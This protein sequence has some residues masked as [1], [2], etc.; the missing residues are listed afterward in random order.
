M[1]KVH[2]ED[3]IIAYQFDAGDQSLGS[4]AYV[5]L[6]GNNALVLEALYKEYYSQLI[7]DLNNNNILIKAVLPSHYHPDHIEG[8]KLLDKVIIYGTDESIKTLNSFPYTQEEKSKMMPTRRV[9]YDDTIVFGSHR[10][11]LRKRPGHSDCS[12]FIEIN[13]AYVHTGDYY[14]TTNTGQDSLPSVVWS[15]I[16]NH[17]IALKEMI[18]YTDKIF[19]MSHGYMTSRIDDLR[20]GIDHRLTYLNRLLDSNN[21][22]SVEEAVQDIE[23]NFVNK[24]FRSYV[25]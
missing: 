8:L 24:V 3:N 22:I 20:D 25:K 11:T 12:M 2:I 1:K 4:N 5:F 14:L 21:S 7:D 17:I 18:K 16:K 15:G 9:N 13:G 19:F 23:C 10:F 6:D